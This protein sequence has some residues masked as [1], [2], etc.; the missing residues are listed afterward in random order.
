MIYGDDAVMIH[1]SLHHVESNCRS[2]NT[3]VSLQVIH[4][5]PS[6]GWQFGHG[7]KVPWRQ[8][9][10][11]AF[12]HPSPKL[13]ITQMAQSTRD[14]IWLDT[15]V[16]SLASWAF[17]ASFVES[18]DELCQVQDGPGTSPAGKDEGFCWICICIYIYI[19]IYICV[20]ICSIHT[21]PSTSIKKSETNLEIFRASFSQLR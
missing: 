8:T 9:G 17:L 1:H 4:V 16:A 10:Q 7:S 15:G 5:A 2:G 19:Y 14:L 11:S 13:S 21:Y 6:W 3:I 20:K 18:L 12:K